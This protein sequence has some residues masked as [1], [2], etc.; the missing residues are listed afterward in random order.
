[1]GQG[2]DSIMAE[3][4][5]RVSSPDFIGRTREL[6]LLR[7]AFERTRSGDPAAV[8]VAG[9]AGVGKTRL[10]DEFAAAAVADGARILSGGCIELSEGSLPFAPVIEALRGLAESTAPEDLEVLLG[11][12]RA[13]FGRLVP[14]LAGPPSG[15][16]SDMA[17]ATGQGRLFELIL[18][19]LQR[20]AER[21]PTVLVIEDLHWADGSTRDL[22][23]FLVRNQRHP[24]AMLLATHRS[25][26]IHRRH[27]LRP[28]LA[29]LDQTKGVERIELE[30]FGRAE[31]FEQLRS[32]LGR[33]PD[34]ELLGRL[35]ELSEGNPFYIEE[36]LYTG[37]ESIQEE[38]PSSL[39]EAVMVRVEALSDDAQEMLRV[40]ATAGRRIEHP[41]LQRVSSLPERDLI[42]ALREAVAHHMLV[43]DD[44]RGSYAFRHALVREA[45]YSDLLPGEKSALHATFA[46]ILREN[47]DLGGTGAAGAAE[48]AYHYYEAH[49]LE[50]ALNA[51]LEAGAAAEQTYAFAEAQQQF[52]R[53]LELWERVDK[54]EETSGW[55]LVDVIR[56]A[57]EDAYMI[58]F[59]RRAIAHIT[60]A[61]ALVD[62]Q[63]DP[64]TAGLLHER[65]GRYHWTNGEGEAALAA[66]HEGVRL[67]PA[68]PPSA[69][70]ARVLAAEGQ[71][72]ML[73][74]RFVESRK[75]CEEAVR[76]A[77]H[78]GARAELG[79]ALNTLGVDVAL[80]GDVDVGIGNLHDSRRIAEEI[81]NV[82]D[83]ARSYANLASVLAWAGRY[84]EA[85]AEHEEAIEVS[86]RMGL[87][88]T[89][90]AWQMSDVAHLYFLTGGWSSVD[91]LTREQGD[92]PGYVRANRLIA[93]GAVAGARGDLD[94]AESDLT[95]A[96]RYSLNITDPQFNGPY[97][98]ARV[99]VALWKGDP[100]A[101]RSF[102]EEGLESLK[103]SEE[104]SD[105]AWLCFLGIQAEADG[106]GDVVRAGD[107][108]DLARSFVVTAETGRTVANPVIFAAAATAAAEHAR[109]TGTSS[110]EIWAEAAGHW[111]RLGHSWFEA[112]ALWR[113]G[114]AH[115]NDG[116]A[117]EAAAPLTRARDLAEDLGARPLLKKV[118]TLARRGKV[119]LPGQE[120]I[121]DESSSLTPREIEVLRLVADGKTN[122]EIAS[123]LFISTKTASVHVS[124]ILAKLGVSSRVQAA[125]IARDMDLVS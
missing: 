13:E 67:L 81:G 9:E 103:H 4:S 38:L 89:Y 92:E 8:F 86:R 56:R 74:S 31:V 29:A 104:L 70:R 19:L 63:K 120:A 47:R 33:D 11:P 66:Y 106:G 122:A 107:L 36:L 26:E 93:R 114:E 35:C 2:L 45:I 55:T 125:G 58:A 82:D 14:E 21:S 10:V 72:L 37:Q 96:R 123:D 102:V 42:E 110:G 108:L 16:L 61:I 24:G 5:Q 46:G 99:L 111:A 100:E 73:S 118:E 32:I 25:D 113:Q 69:E 23:R 18:G 98:Q 76:I 121:K 84:D 62:A 78:V 22:I 7:G 6:A 117:A 15:S 83:I 68:L 41:L 87:G 77:A 112:Y 39:R 105:R 44:K 53:V 12:A 48:L 124:H 59:H 27:P 95:E 54:P 115:L 94:A 50:D 51:S 43:A 71:M 52:E 1:V 57:A 64:V 80:L 20:V 79:H 60:R 28:F 90:G 40:A 119:P 91:D 109:L 97:F 30:R 116:D 88:R 85:I 34:A 3:V 101:A 17:I 75:R 49:L 65:L